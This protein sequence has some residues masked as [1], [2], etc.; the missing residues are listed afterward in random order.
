MR[1]FRILLVCLWL[2]VA[3]LPVRAS[4]LQPLTLRALVEGSD[5]IVM[6]K[7]TESRAFEEGGR[8]MT[9][10]LVAVDETLAGKAEAG[11]TIRVVTLGGE[12]GRL[13]QIVPGEAVL[14][15]GEPVVLC[16]VRTSAGGGQR[17]QVKGASQGRLALVERAG[18]KVLERDFSGAAFV[19]GQ[20]SEEQPAAQLPY[21]LF[22]DEIRKVQGR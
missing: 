20:P 9:E 2:A 21:E 19:S 14:R 16:L 22:L 6:G 7:V 11:A 18:R 3:A 1:I 13:G 4:V 10:H 12:L 17:F 15:K 5:L 8:I